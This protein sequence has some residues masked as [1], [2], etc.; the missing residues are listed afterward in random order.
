[1]SET[2]VPFQVLVDERV[3]KDLKKAPNHII[4]K[5]IKVLDELEEDPIRKRTGVDISKLSGHVDIFR[6][7]IGSWRILYNVDSKRRIVKITTAFP[8]KKGYGKR[9]R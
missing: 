9:V 2:K 7:R 6:V 3:E 8:R 5:F 1:L 4:D